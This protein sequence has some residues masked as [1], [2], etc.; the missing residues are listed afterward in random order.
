MILSAVD[1]IMRLVIIE[2]SSSP[3]EWWLEQ[4]NSDIE[5]N[6]NNDNSNNDKDSSCDVSSPTTLKTSLAIEEKSQREKNVNQRVTWLQLLKQPR[7]IVSLALTAIV[8]TVM[9]AFEV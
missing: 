8:A 3:P 2:R 6:N 4:D 1:F 5:N 7:L 9:S